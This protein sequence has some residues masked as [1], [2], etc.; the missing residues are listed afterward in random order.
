[1]AV[2]LRG[3]VKVDQDGFED[4]DDFWSKAEV[5]SSAT[6]LSAQPLVDD[7]DSYSISEDDEE[8]VIID[9]DEA[10]LPLEDSV[11]S[12]RHSSIR[13]TPVVESSSPL[14]EKESRRSTGNQVSIR[15]IPSSAV[16]SSKKNSARNTSAMENSELRHSL[17]SVP[18]SDIPLRHEEPS[19]HM[20][21]YA[22][23]ATSPISIEIS[24]PIQ[25]LKSPARK[26]KTDSRR[27]SFGK[28]TKNEDVYEKKAVSKKSQPKKNKK[29]SMTPNSYAA[30]MKT[31]KSSDFTRGHTYTDE[32]FVHP[33]TTDRDDTDEEPDASGFT[34]TT[35][36][37]AI[38]NRDVGL[39]DEEEGEEAGRRSNRVTKGR[40]FEFWKNERPVYER[41]QLIGIL[42]AEPT[43]RKRR[44][45]LKKKAQRLILSD[46][47]QSNDEL[48]EP[49][50]IKKPRRL[51]LPSNVT[52]IPREK[53][54]IL[55]TWDEMAEEPREKEVVC[56]SETLMP[57]PLPVLGMRRAGKESLVGLAAQSFSTSESSAP[58]MSGWISGHID[59]PPGAIKGSHL[60]CFY[61]IYTANRCRGSGGVLP[62]LL[63]SDLSGRVSGIRAG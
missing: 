45:V 56:L 30:I 6:L 25:S 53:G 44:H 29:R 39:E 55:S 38:R 11:I 28:D 50:K 2:A 51:Q 20:E 27:V 63:R 48:M 59:L 43:P 10:S 4:I 21:D 54:A 46:D 34:E 40:R 49:R 7:H 32:T 57:Q 12:K 16:A 19:F 8:E 52:F 58:L 41:G 3:P 31:P 13:K 23:D 61:L 15:K 24:Q 9:N 18:P 1:M 47:E 36:L 62:G 33:A 35:Y 37:E 22:N 5:L 42:A 14:L 26:K 17:L 60:P